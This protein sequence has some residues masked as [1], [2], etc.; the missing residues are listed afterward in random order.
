MKLLVFLAIVVLFSACTSSNNAPKN[1]VI[2]A[3]PVPDTQLIYNVEPTSDGKLKVAGQTNLPDETNLEV[4]VR[5]AAN[6]YDTMSAIK[7]KAGEFHSAEFHLNGKGLEP[8]LYI[9]TVIMPLST[10]Q[11]PA[12]RAAIGKNGEKLTGPI[13]RRYENSGATIEVRKAFQLKPDGNIV[14]ADAK[15]IH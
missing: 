11:P 2:E 6:K 10:M 1:T 3:T 15:G 7:V 4:R 5:G 8:G 12:V 13:V 9:V 14:P